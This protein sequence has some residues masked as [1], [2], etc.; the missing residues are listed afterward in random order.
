VTLNLKKWML[1]IPVI[2]LSL[3]AAL[4]FQADIRKSTA[5]FTDHLLRYQTAL[6]GYNRQ[7]Q[8][9]HWNQV[10]DQAAFAPRDGAGALVFQGSMWLIGGWNSVDNI[11]FPMET[12]NEIWR[13][14]DGVLWNLEKAN[15]FWNEAFNPSG[16]WEG[17]HTA[18]YVVYKGKMWI[19]GGDPL[20]GHYQSDIWTSENGT[21]WTWVNKGNP[22]PWD[23]RVLFYTV[24]FQDK[25]WVI[26]GQTL[27]QYA[28][29]NETYYS[30]I[31]TTT[32][33]VNW[34]HI[35]PE[36]PFWNAR[37]MISGS[38]VFNDRIWVLGGGT[39][40]SIVNQHREYYNDVWSS[41]DGIHWTLHTNSA[42]W[43]PRAY[44]N[45]AVFDGAMWV[46]AGYKD[47]NLNDI[48]Y[49]RDGVNWTELPNSPWEPRHASS[50][51]VYKD[52]LWIVAGNNME[53]DVWKLTR[54]PDKSTTESTTSKSMSMPF[55]WQP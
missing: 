9:Y 47:R 20:Q 54:D 53:S 51:F 40:E 13:S 7:D 3:V 10:Q 27:P 34:E 19:I 48:W 31:W 30:D 39:Y 45:V 29:A 26:G 46:L 21:S 28:P 11:N 5:F 55:T 43:S 16:D 36:Q 41:A 1:W 14:Q 6:G 12:N 50:I 2:Q 8:V 15:T 18:G 42:A 38:V 25:I 35:T 44:H 23:P 49:S 32:D 4:A 52:A 17:R 22:P 24:V 37:G 33:G